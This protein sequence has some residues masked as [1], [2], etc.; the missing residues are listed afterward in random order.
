MKRYTKI[1]HVYFHVASMLLTQSSCQHTKLGM[2]S[3]R[4]L[5]VVPQHTNRTQ[6]TEEVPRPIAQAGT[7]QLIED[8]PLNEPFC[9]WVTQEQF[10]HLGLDFK[11]FFYVVYLNNNKALLCYQ[12]EMAP[13]VL[14]VVQDYYTQHPMPLQTIAVKD[15][16]DYE[17]LL[18]KTTGFKMSPRRYNPNCE[19]IGN[20]F[21]FKAMVLEDPSGTKLKPG[22]ITLDIESLHHAWKISYQKHDI[23]C[24]LNT[25]ARA[26][27]LAKPGSS[28]NSKQ[29][30]SFVNNAKQ[31]INEQAEVCKKM[32]F[33]AGATSACLGIGIM[34]VPGLGI[35]G[36][37]VAG[38]GISS[39]AGIYIYTS[40]TQAY[41]KLMK[42][43]F[44]PWSLSK[45]INKYLVGSNYSACAT[46]CYNSFSECTQHI[47][48]DITEQDPVIV[49]FFY[50]LKQWHYV[51]VVGIKKNHLGQVIEFLILDTNKIY[52]KI[53]LD[54]MESLMHN[55]YKTMATALLW[56][57]PRYNY[58]MI[59]FLPK[60]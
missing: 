16:V 7:K 25:A 45:Y 52:Y 17:I 54:D 3:D 22:Y 10:T 5:E 39:I 28:M 53:K 35:L 13:D 41:P 32:T 51:N 60:I 15:A 50:E 42:S 47:K 2:L 57:K 34:C 21:S 24:A 18:T 23:D 1:E 58:Y 29:Y 8:M 27:V 11:D 14:P 59:R 40:T 30:T 6:E 19:C 9:V 36:A 12:E 37:K 38:S 44:G 55:N 33:A 20:T 49:L 46:Y 4:S 48:E 43:M 31:I 26:T 56:D